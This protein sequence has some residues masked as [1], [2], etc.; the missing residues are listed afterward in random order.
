[1]TPEP[2]T[3]APTSTPAHRSP[4]PIVVGV[5]NSPAS[6]AAL[7]WAAGEAAAHGV[8]LVA[9]HVHDP[10]NRQRAAYAQFAVRSGDP[11][12]RPAAAEELIEHGLTSGVEQVFEVGVP[13]EIL[14]LR[15]VGARMLVLGHSEQHRRHEG[16]PFRHEPTLG[17]VARA[18][19]AR[20]TCPVV[21]VPVPDQPP[22][23]ADP[24][25][26]RRQAPE[27]VGARALYPRVCATSVVRR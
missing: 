24:E 23:A 13:S 3:P 10:R 27:L 25:P 11:N 4:A 19:V 15:A 26:A 1:M 18:C 14:V 2:T 12:T 7:R 9:L 5:N 22:A 21:V 20:A 8:P 16:E 6:I 17:T